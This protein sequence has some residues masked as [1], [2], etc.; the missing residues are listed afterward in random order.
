MDCITFA[1]CLDK[2]EDSIFTAID[3]NTPFLPIYY[4]VFIGATT[5]IEFELEFAVTTVIGRTRGKHFDHQFRGF[6][7]FSIFP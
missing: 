3:L 1:E 4:P 7:Q 2:G 6:M 5:R